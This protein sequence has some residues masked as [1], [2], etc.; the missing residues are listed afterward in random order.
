MHVHAVY[1]PIVEL[2]GRRTIGYEALARGPQ[3]SEL[4]RPD[5]LFEAARRSGKL[6]ELDWRCREVAAAGAFEAGLTPPAALFVNVEPEA[7]GSA[8]P[9]AVGAVLRRARRELK[10][11]HEVTERGLVLQPAEMLRAV[12]D[13]RGEGWGIAI[14]DLGSEWSSLA[15]LP[16]IRP[17]VVKLDMELTAGPPSAEHERIARAA[18]AYA[19]WAGASVLAEG[20]ET[21]EHVE[22]ALALGATLGQGWHFGRPGPLEAAAPLHTDATPLAERQP[23][24]SDETP[25]ELVERLLPTAEATKRD[26]LGISMDL[27]GRTLEARDSA[28]VLGCFQ[29]ARHFTPATAQRY[30]E[31]A[32]GSAFV[33]AFGGGLS[34][35]PAPGVR[36][37]SMPDNDRLAGE[38]NV[39]CIGPDFTGALIARDLG[40]DGPDM[41]RRFRFAVTHQ[42]DVVAW[43]A[44]T[45]M[46]K[47][48]KAR[49]FTPADTSVLPAA[50]RGFGWVR[51]RVV[52]PHG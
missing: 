13:L 34:D 6:A 45:L 19:D 47:V 46:L 8:P 22:R 35:A 21:E 29:A 17:D 36:G 44:R 27:E 32:R 23:R 18:R 16:L 24:I 15:M 40:D 51:P 4:E 39:I 31:L 43:A 3:G 50:T 7:L 11:I 26:L 38:W 9:A 33:G 1:Q 42:R 52:T 28:V 49:P 37:A 30:T 10:L 2:E 12:E 5:R 14:D 20:L 48:T 25:F 41:D